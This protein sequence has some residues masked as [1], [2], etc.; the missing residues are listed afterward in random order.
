MLRFVPPSGAPLAVAD[1]LHAW[2]ASLA[3]HGRKSDHLAILAGH[4]G[5]RHLRGTSSGR[6]ALW[7]A[8]KALHRLRPDREVVALPAYTCFSVAAAVVRA[9]LK[10]YP[11]EIDRATLDFD[12]SGLAALPKDNLLCIVASNL[13]GYVNNL[14]HCRKVAKESGAFLVDNAAQALGAVRDSNL[15]GTGG[16][17]GIYSFG[18][19]KALSAMGGGAI[20]TNSDELWQALLEEEDRLPQSTLLHDARLLVELFAYS[21]L[22]RPRLYWIANGMP[23]LKLGV[24]EF[25][26]EFPVYGLPPLSRE[27]I[28]HLFARLDEDNRIRRANAECITKTLDGYST[29]TFP[30][31]AP[32]CLPTMVRLPVLARDANTRKRAVTRL[33][34]A[35]IG[36]SAFYPSAIC[37]IPGIE[38]YMTS[39][40]CHREAAEH[41]SRTLFT[42]P[43]HPLV[44]HRDIEQMID[45]L[46][47]LQVEGA[48]EDAGCQ[49]VIRSRRLNADWQ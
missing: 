18:R 8:L 3:A 47:E 31:P 6:A 27:L 29:F 7:L 34:Q 19:G 35:G 5:V 38:R 23:F 16:D 4:L 41:L 17:V 2:R 42:L 40:N 33:R 20:V 25:N 1:I 36:A 9:G 21:V 32:N 48:P 12:A 24:T 49:E 28:V 44:H 10:L 37:D 13:F 46:G 30:Q 43:V 11:L 45:I 22:L 39:A 14:S 15:A 26:A